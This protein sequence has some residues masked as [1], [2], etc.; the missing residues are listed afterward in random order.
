VR[1][2]RLGRTIVGKIGEARKEGARHEKDWN[3]LYCVM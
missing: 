2:E 1:P 3:S